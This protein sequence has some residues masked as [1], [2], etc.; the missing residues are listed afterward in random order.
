VILLFVA[1]FLASIWPIYPFFSRIHPIVLGL[2]FSLVYLIILLLFSF[3]VLLS[4]YLW[5]SRN[6]RLD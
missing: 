2:P 6:G 3:S 4:L 1:V 5:E